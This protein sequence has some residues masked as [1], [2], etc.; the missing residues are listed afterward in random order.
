M[1]NA[2]NLTNQE[3]L[4]FYPNKIGNSWSYLWVYYN[5]QWDY[6]EAKRDEI[7]IPKD[8]TVNN[9]NYKLI[10]YNYGG[11]NNEKYCERVDSITGDILRIS[12]FDTEEINRVD[13]IYAEIGDT[14]S[15]QNNRYLLYCDKM[16]ILSIRDTM[17]NDFET[18]IREVVG[19]PMNK[20]LFFARNIGT[21]GSSKNY[22]IDSANVNGIIHSDISSDI[23]DVDVSKAI[24][25]NFVLHQNYPNPFNPTTIINYSIPKAE[26]VSLKVYDI[27]GRRVVNLVDEY[28]KTGNYKI[29]FDAS[30]LSSGIYY[31]KLRSGGFTETRKLILLR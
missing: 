26:F 17:I 5:S 10:E 3:M 1:L 28:Q 21:L 24:V 13:S 18:T 2:Q 30:N 4:E 25:N 9:K 22:W 27:L 8:T 14:I 15:I 19:L 12:D 20:K 7:F 16:V 6:Y 29:R 23:T 11:F 31:Y